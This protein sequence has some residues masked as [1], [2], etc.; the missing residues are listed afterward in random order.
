MDSQSRR[1]VPVLGLVGVLLATLATGACS[2]KEPEGGFQPPRDV[3]GP[4]AAVNF[5]ATTNERFGSMR[6]PSAAGAGTGGAMGGGMEAGAGF[7]W[8][9]P[10]GWTP[11]ETSAMRNANFRVAGD[12]KAECYLSILGGEAGGLT[13]NVNRWR[14]QVALPPLS[15]AEIAAL[16]RATLLGRQGVL[17]DF[18]GTWK[19]M[20]GTSNEAGWRLTGILDVSPEGSAFLKMTGPDAKIAAEKEHFLALAKSLRPGGAPSDPHAEMG[21]AASAAPGGDP[22]A[23]IPGAP[24]IGGDMSGQAMP[25]AMP[26]AGDQQG[27]HWKAPAGWKQAAEKPARVVTFNPAEGVECYVTVLG[28]DGGGLEANL[29][30]WRGQMG[31]ADLAA[32]EFQELPH[33]PILG[34][35]GRLIAIDGAGDKAGKQMLGAV[36]LVGGRS[37]FVKMTG[38]KDAVQKEREHFTAFAQS[39]EEAK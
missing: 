4:S 1:D 2:K 14:S 22:H 17:V 25:G 28:G 3:Q 7:A 27:L 9:L 39:L 32:S 21:G 38:P 35:D 23:G 15:D 34:S 19:G 12:E 10:P 6:M 31:C 26:A 33:I 36:A 13:S 16:P 24:S 11:L 5:G 20:G 29:N 18:V 37:V 30:R 8:D